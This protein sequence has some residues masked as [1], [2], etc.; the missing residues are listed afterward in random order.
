LRQSLAK[1]VIVRFLLTIICLCFP[2]FAAAKAP[3]VKLISWGGVYY[4]NSLTPSDEGNASLDLT[5]KISLDF[6][7]TMGKGKLIPYV[8]L[9]TQ[10]DSLGYVYNSKDKITAGIALN[11][12][13]KRHANVS[14]GVKYAYDYRQLAGYGYSGVGLTADYGLYR[15]WP[16][17]NGQR[18]VLAG[19]A[20]LRY[21]GSVAPADKDNIIGQGR[22]TLSR[23]RPLGH[24]KFKGAGFTALGLF[25]DTDYNDFNNKVQLDF[26]LQ[27]KRKFKNTDLTLSAKYRI[28]HR[29]KTEKTYSGV[30]VG[31]SWL[32]ISKPRSGV[33][34]PR[35]KAKGWLRKLIRI[36][37]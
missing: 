25:K 36:D 13:V 8:T 30:I 3:N 34:K 5:S 18:V 28:D 20:N 15:S 9:Y 21:P 7:W 29:F 4:P 1:G 2:Q 22:F 24:T 23:E 26:G 31:L 35:N 27:L 19:W 11:Y 37:T 14:F 6:D 17:E 32:T 33:N 12:K 10:R 16:K